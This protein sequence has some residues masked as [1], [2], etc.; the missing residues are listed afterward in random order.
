MQDW[1]PSDFSCYVTRFRGE[2]FLKLSKH[3][4]PHIVDETVFELTTDI[5]NACCSKQ[6][7]DKLAALKC[8]LY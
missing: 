1:G 2:E 5:S 6:L 4:A 8:F 7:G 3:K